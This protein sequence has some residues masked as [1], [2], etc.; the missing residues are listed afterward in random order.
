MKRGRKPLDPKG[1][2][3]SSIPVRLP[4]DLH[5]KA[6]RVAGERGMKVVELIRSALEHELSNYVYTNRTVVRPGRY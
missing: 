6:C 1:R 3:S 2:P 4:P 5:D